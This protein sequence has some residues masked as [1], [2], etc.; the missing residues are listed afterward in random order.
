MRLISI[1]AAL[2]VAAVGLAVRAGAAE[3]FGTTACPGVAPGAAMQ[4]PQQNFYTMGFFFSGTKGREKATYFGTVG[5]LVLPSA[6][7]KTWSGNGPVV[8]DVNGKPIGRF[9]YAFNVETPA[10]DSFGLVKLN[11]GVKYSPSVCHFG[12]PTAIYKGLSLTPVQVQMYGQSIGI[13]EL[14]PARSGFAANTADPEQVAVIAPAPAFITG[15][16]DDGAPVL[17]GGQAIGFMTAAVSLGTQDGIQVRRVTPLVNKAQKATG[18]K[19][20]MLT[21]KAL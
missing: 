15:L 11:K 3:P 20:T 17:S 2:A 9:V 19:L 10:A 6:G 21:S 16:G 12:G 4:D 5:G 14:M 13:G 1:L 18:I 7:T 8:R